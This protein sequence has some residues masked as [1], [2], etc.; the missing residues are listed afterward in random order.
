MGGIQHH[1]DH[2]ST[3]GG[4][5][6][7]EPP[8]PVGDDGVGGAQGKDQGNYADSSNKNGNSQSAQR[9]SVGVQQCRETT[10]GGGR[11]RLSALLTPLLNQGGFLLRAVR[12]ASILAF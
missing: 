5:G 11:A 1:E 9:G 3:A 4:D 12:H 10:G 8:E 2:E 7:D 6:G